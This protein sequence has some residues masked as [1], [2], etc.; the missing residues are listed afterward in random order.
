MRLLKAYLHRHCFRWTLIPLNTEFSE[1]EKEMLRHGDNGE[2]R[3][4][5]P[6]HKTADRST[7]TSQVQK[8][9]TGIIQS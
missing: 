7:T 3:Q 1:E 2:R 5:V 9:R 4:T 8:M 6:A